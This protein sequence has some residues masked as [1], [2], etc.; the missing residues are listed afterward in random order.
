MAP[1]EGKLCITTPE[2]PPHRWGGLALTAAKVAFHARDL[3]LDVHVANFTVEDS[4]TVLLDENRETCIGEGITVHHLTVGRERLRDGAREL[5]DCPHTLTLQMMYQSIEILHRQERFNFF[6]SFFLYPVGYITGLFARRCSVPS[7]ATIVGNDVKKYIFSPEKSAVCRSALENADRIVGLSQDLIDM[8][9]ALTPVRHKARVIHNSVVIPR[10]EW[11]ATGRDGPFRIGCAGIFKYAKGLPY[12]FKA[13]E[14]VARHRNVALELVGELRDSERK[15]Y[16][17]MLARTG[18]GDLVRL[19]GRMPHDQ[20]P[21]WFANLDLFVLPSLTEGCPNVLMEAMACGTP[22]VATRIG[23]VEDLIEDGVSGLIVPWGD[24]ASL[25]S[26]M[27]RVMENAQLAVSL[28]AS[29][30]SKMR[31]FSS[32]RERKAWASV[33]GELADLI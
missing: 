24:S 32:E 17:R 25:G 3:G 15:V 30:R 6:H 27:S 2:F 12:L 16:D 28:G 33:Y 9:D 19:S 11:T 31:E 5:W 13:V 1:L 26:A 22:C 20:M 21:R 4:V 18:I 7:I 8:A 14:N 23:A 29:A 10:Q